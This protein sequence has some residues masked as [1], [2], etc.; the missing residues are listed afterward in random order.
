MKTLKKLTRGLILLITSIAFF[1][2][3]RA[4]GLV[5]FVTDTNDGVR[6]SNLRGA[7]IA[8]NR[9]GGKNTII[10]GQPFGQR[11]NNIQRTFRLT[12]PGADETNART[13]DL[14]ITRGNLTIVGMSPNVTIDA[15][16]L[17]DRVFQVFSNAHLTLED[18][19]IT[20]GT[21]PQAQQGSFYTPTLGAEFGGAIYNAGVLTLNACVITNNTSGGG[22]SNPGNAGGQGGGDG[23]GIYNSGILTANDC[24]I[25]GNF[26]GGGVDGTQ[27][28]NGGGIENDGIC[29]LTR[30]I[31]SKNQNG[32]GGGPAGNA[33]GFG[34]SGGN[35][36]GIFN[37]GTIILNNCVVS[38]NLSG[39]GSDGG[40]P[41]WTTIG[42]S[43][44]SAGNG[45]SGAGIHNAGQMQIK[46]SAVYDNNCGNGGAGGNGTGA[47]AS[48]GEG[49]DGG[50][51]FNAQNLAISSSTISGNF[52]G[53]GGTGAAGWYAIGGI[54]GDGGNG[55]AIYNAGMLNLTS[56]TIALNSAGIGGNSGNS[57]NFSSA[58]AGGQGGSGGGVLNEGS[59]TN[60]IVRNS[61]IA[62]NTPNIGGMGGTNTIDNTTEETI[63]VSGL[64]GAGFDAIGDFTSLGFNLIGMADG[65]IGFINGINADQVGSKANPTNPLLGPLQMNGG[66]TPTHALLPG[67]PAIDQG[68]CFGI[69]TDQ[70]GHRRPYNYPSISNAVGG[71]GSDIGAFE[72]DTH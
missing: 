30:C 36:G 71:D 33:L 41:A 52:S 57:R 14:D 39:Q 28:G 68:N 9:I 4:Q 66:F 24:Q 12:I 18:L 67:S 35:G 16:G 15:T 37:A 10:L 26:T 5:F 6:I 47:G 70:R 7:I 56:C 63:G 64:S 43:G 29:Y 61:L 23:G 45:G 69:H 49:G 72:L 55:G 53:N 51:I 13:G 8:A 22:G 11:R 65:S 25:I 34:G 17:G 1:V 32:S 20:G 44:G 2:A 42:S 31:I 50:G 21:A 62:L 58:A 60:A 27:G 46:F 3:P 40:S 38:E 19:T 59:S 48:G 54:G